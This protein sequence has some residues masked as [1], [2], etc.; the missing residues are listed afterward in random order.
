MQYDEDL[1]ERQT[2]A[3]SSIRQL[4][5]KY[6]DDY[7]FGLEK[8]KK[9]PEEF[10]SEFEKAGF[11]AAP[12]PEVYGGPGLSIKDASLILEE[13]NSLGGNCQPFHGQFYLLWMLSRFAS[14]E[15]KREYLP[16]IAKGELRLQTFALTEPEAGTETTKIRTFAEKDGDTYRISGHKIFISRY[17]Q[18]DLMVLAARTTPYEAAA[19]KTEGLSL[20]LVPLAEAR[21]IRHSKIDV[22]FNTQTYELF[23]EGLEL[24]ERYRIGEE[25]A[26]FKYLL[27]ILN[28]ERIL[29]A[30]ECVGDA[31]WFIDRAVNYVKARNVYGKPIGANQGVQFPLADVYANLVAAREA[32]SKAADLFDQ[33]A[34]LKNVGAHANIAKYLATECSWNAANIAM[35]VYGG[36]GMAL[37]SHV[38]RKFRETRLYRVAPIPQNLVLAYIAQSVMEL[39]R[40]Y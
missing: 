19:K 39:P 35:D 25:G 7:W 12:I 9:Y 21:G 37:D 1:N 34:D 23:I 38:E 11:A 33:G 20:F 5:T 17:E 14:D 3:I 36:Y 8:E 24:P 22:M 16:K 4:M 18:S 10:V 30:S 6:G 32:R 26:G 29:L 31:R 2:L 28:P 27:N 15:L 13:I 40:S